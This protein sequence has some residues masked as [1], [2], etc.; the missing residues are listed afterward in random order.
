MRIQSRG[1]VDNLNDPISIRFRRHQW[2][3][4][5]NNNGGSIDNMDYLRLLDL[6][7]RR[8]QQG[9]LL[10]RRPCCFRT[11]YRLQSSL[12][13]TKLFRS[14][15][16]KRIQWESRVSSSNSKRTHEASI[17]LL[18]FVNPPIRQEHLQEPVAEWSTRWLGWWWMEEEIKI[19]MT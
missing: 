5:E 17:E 16:A 19:Q 13:F 2:L 9:W 8:D 12:D 10:F 7:K 11:L 3:D 18:P 4:G 6:A 14:L 1:G 15:F